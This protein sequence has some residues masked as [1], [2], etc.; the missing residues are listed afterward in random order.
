MFEIK[1]LHCALNGV[2]ILK[3]INFCVNDGEIV[4]LVGSSGAGKTTVLRNLCGFIKPVGGEILIDGKL[5]RK[6]HHGDIGLIPQGQALFDHMT[7]LQ[8]VAYALRKVKKISAIR[9]KN[10]AM[11]MID[12]FGL[13]DKHNVYPSQL[14]GGQK[15]RVAIAR[16][17]VMEPKILLFDEPTA[18]LDPEVAKNV[19]DTILEISKTGIT[20]LVVTHDLLMAKKIS[21]R[22]LFIDGGQILED[23]STE[24]FFKQPKSEK[25][26]KFLSNVLMN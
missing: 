24:E 12:R 2:E 10:I 1:K 20:I 19:A 21:N 9:S 22:I 17:L 6:L 14:S 26:A 11:S 7:V 13:T 23:S 8:N 25:A 18:G 15:Q 3:G 16:S 4:S 5:K